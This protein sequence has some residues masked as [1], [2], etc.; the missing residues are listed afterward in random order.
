MSVSVDS[1][2]PVEMKLRQLV[3]RLSISTSWST[4]ILN[5]A[6]RSEVLVSLGALFANASL[7]ED[8]GGVRQ[9]RECE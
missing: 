6:I 7:F 5:E 8:V 3:R 9:Q 2:V 4:G 1:T